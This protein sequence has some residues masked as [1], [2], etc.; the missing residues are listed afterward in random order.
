MNPKT[1]SVLPILLAFVITSTLAH[2]DSGAQASARYLANEG[3]LVS[4]QQTKVLFDPFFHNDYGTYQL[5]P[6]TIRNAIF[7][8]EPPYDGINAIVISHAHGDHFNAEETVMFLKKHPKITLVAPSQAIALVTKAQGGDTLHK[9]LISLKL[10]LGDAPKI[11]S[12]EN[13]TIESIRIPHAGWPQRKEV[14]NLV[15]RVTLNDR[16]RIMHMGDADPSDEHFQPYKSHWEKSTSDLAF[17]PYWFFLNSDGQSILRQRINATQSI[18]VH[19]PI[20]IPLKLV[21]SNNDFFSIPGEVRLFEASDR[22]TSER[23]NLPVQSTL[24]IQ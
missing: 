10:E 20:E 4:E 22:H 5:V 13:L 1:S 24:Q 18:G 17:P 9:Q 21:R 16:F 15:H 3:V 11:T 23:K 7:N 8:A 12:L 2:D 6:E 14:M 19:V